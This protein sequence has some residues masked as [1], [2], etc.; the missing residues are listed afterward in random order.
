MPRTALG[1]PKA[2]MVWADIT[3]HIYS[4]QAASWCFFKAL[5]LGRPGLCEAQPQD[6]FAIIT[7]SEAKTVNHPRSW[8]RMR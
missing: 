6:S 8:Q 4:I 2:N 7:S 5:L 1:D 3:K